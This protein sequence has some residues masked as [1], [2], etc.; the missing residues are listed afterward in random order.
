VLTTAGLRTHGTTHQQP[1]RAF[2]LHERAALQPLPARPY[3]IVVWKQAELHRDLHVVFEKSFY[4]APHRLVGKQL[5]VAGTGDFVRIYDEWEL[6]AQH[7]AAKAAGTRRTDP[8]HL[9]AEQRAY[10]EQSPAWCRRVAADIG[11]HVAKMVEDLLAERPSDRLPTVQGILKL[12]RKY[13]NARLDRAC[14]RALLFGEMKYRTVRNILE[15]GLDAQPMPG[16]EPES[17]PSNSPRPRFARDGRELFPGPGEGED[18]C[19]RPLN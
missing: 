16:I 15:N 17:P 11:P 10:F 1:L 4:S 2:E 3:E 8:T 6:V 14:Q 19:H 5:W 9:P 7:V 18:Q 12:R 13:S